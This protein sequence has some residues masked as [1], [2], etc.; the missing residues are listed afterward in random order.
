MF[1]RLGIPDL[2]DEATLQADDKRT[3]SAFGQPAKAVLWY[4]MGFLPRALYNPS[5]L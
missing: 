4:G 5:V 1:E 3:Q 2:I